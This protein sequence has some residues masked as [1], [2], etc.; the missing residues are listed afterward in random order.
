MSGPSD[1]FAGGGEMGER[2]RAFDW[3]RT[4]LGPVES[5]SPAL[6]MMVAFLLANRFPLLLWW[7]PEYISIY[8]DAYCPVLG[9]K[10]PWALGRPVRECWSEVWNI[11]EPLID[12][13][14]QGGP[15]TWMEDM[16]LEINRY[17]FLEETHFTIAYSPVPDETAPR[18]IGGVLATVHEITEKVVGERRIGALRDLGACTAEAKTAEG[19]CAS[20]AEGL[21]GHAKDVPFV[22]LYLIDQD[23]K[24]ARLAG[25]SGVVAGEGTAPTFVDLD[26][27]AKQDVGWPLAEARD[28]KGAVTVENL[29]ARIPNIPAGP[30][31]DPPRTAVIVPI[32]SNIAHRLAGFM[33][34]GASPRLK[35]DDHYLSFLE[36][37]AA[38]IATAI[39]N[40]RAYEEERKRAEALAEIDR[41]KT[42]FFSNVSHEFRTPLTLMLAPI[43]EALGDESSEALAEV[44]RERL[45]VAHRNSLRLL[46]LV[47]TL[48][49]FSRIEA[50]RAQASYEPT[51]L[52]ALTTEL[53]SNFRSA[54]ERAGIQL[55]VDCPPLPEPVHIDRDMWEKI[56]LNLLSNAF[57]FTFQGRISVRFRA[58]GDVA[59]LVVQDTGVGVPPSEMPRLFER[60][61]RIEGQKGRSY[62]G[63]GIGLALVQELIRLHGGTITG[64]SEIGKGTA[65]IVSLPF[66]TDHL[67]TERIGGE[68]TLASTSVRADTF[69]EEALRWLPGDAGAE[70]RPIGSGAELLSPAPISTGERPHVLVAD[71]NSDMRNYIHQLLGKHFR[72]QAVSDGQAALD[73][74]GQ[75]RPDLVIADVMMPG[76]D[77]FGLL[78]EIRADPGLRGLP[79]MMLSARAGDEARRE[80]L[81]AG[82]NDYLIKPFSAP[83]LVCRV[84][85]NLQLARLRREA[86]RDLL[87]KEERLRDTNAELAQRVADLQIA[88]EEAKDSRRAALNLMEDAVQSRAS[89][90]VEIA[91]RRRGEERQHLLTDELNHRVKNTL[92][93]VQSIAAQ[94]LKDVL[95]KDR[96][97]D[98][99]NRLMALSRTHDLLL[100]R[101]WQ[102]VSLSELLVLELQPYGSDENSRFVLDGPAITVKPKAGLALGLAF[103]ELVTNAAKYGAFSKPTGQVRIVW[104]LVSASEHRALRL[105]WTETGGPPVKKIG[106]KGFGTM[107]I[108]R[109]LSLELDGEVQVDFDPSGL[110]CTIEIPL[111]EAGD[112][113]GGVADGQ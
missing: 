20:A 63:S 41:A 32:K 11:L 33:V 74:I 49:D 77:G 101:S 93:T 3:T 110:V 113:V 18:G 91:E 15:A 27:A 52:A 85:S 53:A 100:R 30:W 105:K 26:P 109:G 17:G 64:Q 47:N 45:H 38:Q 98:F 67:P 83:E 54:C 22:L 69:V 61:H 35:L 82:A 84:E 16:L 10:H 112:G 14:F 19:A 62:E 78:S 57:K 59:E 99:E 9:T 37:V 4:P 108:Q 76:L 66:G 96:Q 36:L 58:R 65:F 43:E 34:A 80:G 7:D 97:K 5:W 6:R 106:R 56:V 51:D 12:T 111:S 55:V 50:G 92:A 89:M 87:E 95:D 70:I 39:A 88:A 48:L 21:A 1:L 60:F 8:N 71:D 86:E 28:R 44:Q 13:P 103:H 29:A 75:H 23:G 81:R 79:V 42:L 72:V 107:V 24:R 102:S 25:T 31:S 90:L 68:Y 94:T 2:M 104:E 73:A 46:K 40:A